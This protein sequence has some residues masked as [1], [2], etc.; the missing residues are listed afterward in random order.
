M[1]VE[2]DDGELC[3]LVQASS[4]FL[5]RWKED[6]ASYQHWWSVVAFFP[7]FAYLTVPNH[8]GEHVPSCFLVYLS[9]ATLSVSAEDTCSNFSF[10]PLSMYRPNIFHTTFSKKCHMPNDRSI[11][12]FGYRTCCCLSRTLQSSRTRQLAS[13]QFLLA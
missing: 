10:V 2:G 12:A 1:Y 8:S 13:R 7:P 4:R 6:G 3:Q 5:G 11:T 9:P